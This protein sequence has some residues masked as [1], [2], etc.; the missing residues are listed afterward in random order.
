MLVRLLLAVLMLTGPLPVRVCT[1]AA[2]SA[3]V[4]PT[5]GAVAQPSTPEKG[6][7]CGHRTATPADADSDLDRGS[8][9][10]AACSASDRAPAHDGHERDCPALNPRVVLPAVQTGVTDLP[11][12]GD[13]SL[14]A[15]LEPTHGVLAEATPPHL[16][17]PARSA[18][19]L[20]LSLLSIR[21]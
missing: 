18:V 17:K 7:R 6:C 8:G 19:P 12:Y 16:Y 5:A 2:A 21:I 14:P 11:A 9:R 15:P 10:C 13:A 3:P 20:F 4:A 1:C